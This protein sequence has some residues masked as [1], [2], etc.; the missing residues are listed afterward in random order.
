MTGLIV[1]GMVAQVPDAPSQY[2]PWLLAAWLCVTMIAGRGPGYAA[3][4]FGALAVALFAL[5]GAGFAVADP[6][7]ATGLVGLIAAGL[8]IVIG[9]GRARERA[10]FFRDHAAFLGE[11]NAGL[12]AITS[13]FSHRLRNDLSGLIATAQLRSATAELPETRAA[14]GAMGDRI[15]ALASVYARLD[16]KRSPSATIGLRAFIEGLCE[17]LRFAHLSVRPI[18][19]TVDVMEVSVRAGRAVLIGLV[20]NELLTNASK[21][22]F[23]DDRPGTITVSLHAHPART[24]IWQLRVV[25]DGVGLSDAGVGTGLGQKLIKARASQLGG[26]FSLAR[27]DG[28][29]VGQ[30]DFPASDGPAG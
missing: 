5:R 2:Y 7:D 25:D 19:L 16:T 11:E 6:D 24:G 3:L 20:V 30:L 1:W 12:R 14:L 17:D 26:M 15:T 29:T 10:A 23:P 4:G 9:L 13:E 18:G 28:F 8:L 27:H 22:A 21:Y